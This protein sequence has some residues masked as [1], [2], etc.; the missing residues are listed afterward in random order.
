[1]SVRDW[2]AKMAATFGPLLTKVVRE[3]LQSLLAG[4]A[5][6]LQPDPDRGMRNVD[7]FGK[8]VLDEAVN[9][10]PRTRPFRRALLRNIRD[11]A[12]VS[13]KLTKAERKEVRTICAACE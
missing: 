12:A 4:I 3:W 11:H 8:T 10:T 5:A 13:E 1:M 2:L 9:R 6:E 7:E